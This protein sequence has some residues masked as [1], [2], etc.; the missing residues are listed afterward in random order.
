M[1]KYKLEER[2]IK[3]IPGTDKEVK[4]DLE[5]LLGFPNKNWNPA[6]GKGKIVLRY[7]YSVNGQRRKF[8]LGSY[9]QNTIKQLTSAYKG[10]VGNVAQGQ[11][12]QE[13]RD[14]E[15]HSA[16]LEKVENATTKT[17]AE[18]GREFIEDYCKVKKSSWGEDQRILNKYILNR[19]I[20]KMLI[21]DVEKH[22]LAALLKDIT[23][24][25]ISKSPGR[26]GHQPADKKGSPVMANR[27]RSWLSKCWT[28]AEDNGYVKYNV[29]LRLPSNDEEQRDRVL[30]EN[31]I[32][33]FWNN[34]DVIE[35]KEVRRALSTVLITAQ[36]PGEVASVHSAHIDSDEWV[37]PATKHKSKR[38]RKAAHL[39]P[40]SSLAKEY[41]IGDGYIFPSDRADHIC[42]STLAHAMADVMSAAGIVEYYCHK[43]EED[44][45]VPTPHD[46]RRT[47]STQIESKFGEYIPHR[48]LNH[49]KGA[50]AMYALYDYA[51]EKTKALN[52]WDRKLRQI[53]GQPIDNVIHLSA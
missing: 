26:G 52:W 17:L 15:R 40:L 22:H 1:L 34:L 9:P 35:N 48:I 6:T 38:Y 7:R 8:K 3:S 16:Q 4:F 39:V 47:A 36:R 2:S 32:R 51:P 53:L 33:L 31:E 5:G 28:Y 45:P 11:D 30:N 29:A 23:K 49:S 18:V 14:Q 50:L 44:I 27:V 42:E 12:P 37:I 21:R 41:L 25:G 13:Q 46:L 43:K 20:S 19:P 10:A 24:N